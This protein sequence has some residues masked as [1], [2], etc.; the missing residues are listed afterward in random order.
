MILLKIILF[1]FAILY[2]ML[3][4]IRNHLYRIGY[5]HSFTFDKCVIGI[6]NLTMG[7]TG[8][9]PMIEY[10]IRLL[11]EKYPVAV[12]SRGY[13]R[14]TKGIQFANADATAKTI[15]DEPLQFFTKYGNEVKVV[16]CADR[17]FAIPN[18]LHEYPDVQLVLMD[19]AF[20][21]LA[22]RP[23][24]NLL[25]TE[26]E[27]PFY[28]DFILPVGRLRESR[29]GS[30]RAD[31]IIVTKCPSS[32]SEHEVDMMENRIKY[33]SGEKQIYF[34]TINYLAP[35]SFSGSGSGTSNKIV[36]VT[37]IANTLPLVRYIASNFQLVHHFKY[38]DH[39]GYTPEEVKSIQS[40]LDIQAEGAIVLTT[41]KD[42]MRLKDPLL[43]SALDTTRWFYLPIEVSFLRNGS[44][45]DN[46]VISVIERTLNQ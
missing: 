9:S 12:L 28:H 40:Y 19:D 23:H 33:F 34:S 17:A 5:K 27:K 22:V 16:S 21:H 7:G 3:M 14:S 32:I 31:A 45:F 24:L 43:I 2:D 10:M 46:M 15:G 18:I 37:G 35:I 26:Y 30:T 11:K 20:Q 38:A 41:E 36:L 42:M 44:E 13:G 4:R 6:G 25:L 39:H 1:P 8:K 29:S